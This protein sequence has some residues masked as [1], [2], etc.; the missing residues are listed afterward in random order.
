ML[1]SEVLKVFAYGTLRGHLAHLD[2]HSVNTVPAPVDVEIVLKLRLA[3]CHTLK[4]AGPS[5]LVGS[6]MFS[7]L[8]LV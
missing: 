5:F 6:R 3:A 2:S 7:W 4:Y 1:P 8:F